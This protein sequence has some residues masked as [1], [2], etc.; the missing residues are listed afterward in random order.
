M[1]LVDKSKKGLVFMKRKR[2]D[3]DREYRIHESDDL[4]KLTSEEIEQSYNILKEYDKKER[5]KK[6]KIKKFFHR[7][8]KK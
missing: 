8:F 5:S 6:G 4:F 7:I 3:H 2:P 1:V